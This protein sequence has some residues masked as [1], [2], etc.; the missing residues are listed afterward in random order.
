LKRRGEVE[1]DLGV[2]V[3]RPCR[4]HGDDRHDRAIQSATVIAAIDLMR[5]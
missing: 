4:D 2:E 3:H 1:G 5:R